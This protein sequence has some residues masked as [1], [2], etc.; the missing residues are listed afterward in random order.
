[1]GANS[2]LSESQASIYFNIMQI[3]IANPEL[4]FNQLIMNLQHEYSNRND[5][6]LVRDDTKTIDAFYLTDEK[7]AEFLQDFIDELI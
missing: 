4:R 6:A 1:M 5:F 3:W 7:F 2:V